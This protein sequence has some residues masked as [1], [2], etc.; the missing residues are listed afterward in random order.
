MVKVRAAA[1]DVDGT[2]TV[3]RGDTKLDCCGITAVRVLESRGIKVSLISGN[4][5]PVVAGLSVYLGASGPALGEN[6][7]VAFYRG[8]VIH[9]CNGRP[10]EGLVEEL[11]SLGFVESWQNRFRFHE[12]ALVPEDPS[13]R[14]DR[15]FIESAIRLVESWGFKAVWSGYALHVQP[16]GGG[17]DA[18]LRAAARILGLDP[19]DFLAIGDGENDVPMLKIAGV[20][21][22]PGDASREAKEA[23]GI[24]ANLPGAKGAM[25]II[26]KVLGIRWDGRC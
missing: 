6:G 23:A 25:E 8:E 14:R 22:A 13:K 4:S 11:K 15:S 5:L 17:K 3:A 16:P 26:S 21:G 19:G 9:V 1:I 24:V 10:D 20:S 2:L 7:C 18:G 12:V